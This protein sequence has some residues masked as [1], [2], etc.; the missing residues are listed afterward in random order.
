[1]STE[2]ADAGTANTREVFLSP[3]TL[4]EH[5]Q[6]HMRLTRRTVEAFPEDE[7]FTFSAG[8]MRPFSAMVLEVALMVRPTLQHLLREGA[9]FGMERWAE[10][11]E[12]AQR[13]TTTR[14]EL[15]K[16]W[17]ESS[18]YLQEAWPRISVERFHATE[19]AFELPPMPNQYLVLY[20][21]DNEIHHRAQG[22]VY[23]RMLGIEPPAFWE[24]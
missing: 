24:R 5:W 9:D 4:L 18:A 23:L 22:F 11:T 8:P 7:L 16:R 10:E 20:A 12:T 21:V 17:D 3:A 6:G 14:A 2:T 19:S 15:L 13:E 1:M